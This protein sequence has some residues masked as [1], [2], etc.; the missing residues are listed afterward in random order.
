[1]PSRRGGRLGSVG[2]LVL[3]LAVL[4]AGNAEETG[5]D[6]VLTADKATYARSEPIVLTIAVV[7]RGPDPVTLQF[8]TAQRYDVVIRTADQVDV[9]RW[10]DGQMFAQVL[11]SQ[12]VRGRGV[13]RYRVTVRHRLPAGRHTVVASVP[14]EG[15]ALEA[16]LP[17][18][19]R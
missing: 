6:L 18:T 11:G 12:T 2:V 9:W 7:N 14:A 3:A 13:L 1:M 10:S 17:I 16:S 19:V 15:A 5:V 4:G 8:L